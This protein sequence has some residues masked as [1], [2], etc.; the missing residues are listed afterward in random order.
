M[1]EGRVKGLGR[2]GERRNKAESKV[3]I[4]RE[5]AGAGKIQRKKRERGN[6][7]GENELQGFLFTENYKG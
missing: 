3:E 7:E 2:I 1:G 6:R 4:E 5:K